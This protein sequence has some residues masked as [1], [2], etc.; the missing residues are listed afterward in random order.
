VTQRRGLGASGW[1]AH[2]AYVPGDTDTLTVA[3][4]PAEQLLP[5][6]TTDKEQ[7]PWLT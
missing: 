7:L 2:V 5:I 4:V 1:V 3:W 6:T